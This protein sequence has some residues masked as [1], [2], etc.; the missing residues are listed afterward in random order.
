VAS[1]LSV[2]DVFPFALAGTQLRYGLS[3]YT[4]TSTLSLVV[5]SFNSIEKKPEF[6]QHRLNNRPLPHGHRSSR[7]SFSFNSLSPWNTLTTN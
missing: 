4:K 7:P 3:G 6:R 5:V 1:V 2:V